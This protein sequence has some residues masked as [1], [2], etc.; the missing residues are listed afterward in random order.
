MEKNKEDRSLPIKNSISLDIKNMTI[1]EIAESLKEG[2]LQNVD[3]DEDIILQCLSYFQEQCYTDDMIA[4]FLDRN[5]RTIRRY[6]DKLRKKNSLILGEDF[7]K[8][9]LGDMLVNWKRQLSYFIRLAN[10]EDVSSLDRMRAL[11]YTHQIQ[12]DIVDTL[13]K[14]G[15]LS[16]ERGSAD[17]DREEAKLEE[18]LKDIYFVTDENLDGV[19]PEDIGNL[20]AKIL[21]F[22]EDETKLLISKYNTKPNEEKK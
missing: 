12:R 6:K 3:I 16:K 22:I 9:L 21:K 7:Q 15:Y 14:Y 5:S 18:N 10:K 2:K 17:L 8:D 11:F 4:S 1:P 19:P 13:G 20:H